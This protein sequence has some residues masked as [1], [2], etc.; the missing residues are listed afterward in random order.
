MPCILSTTKWFVKLWMERND[1]NRKIISGIGFR[2]W[3]M[4]RFSFSLLAGVDVLLKRPILVF[5]SYHQAEG[6]KRT[7]YLIA[8]A[9]V[10]K[11]ANVKE[12]GKNYFMDLVHRWSTPAP[13]P[14]APT[15][16]F[17]GKYFAEKH[18]KARLCVDETEVWPSLVDCFNAHLENLKLYVSI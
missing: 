12:T 9:K 7:L 16:H 11:K 2:L 14:Q 4:G 13:T 3:K 15:L 17:K 10:D 6:G 8:I 1:V 18:W 5:L